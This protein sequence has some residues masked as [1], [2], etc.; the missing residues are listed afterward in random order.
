MTQMNSV[1][2]H[3]L[4]GIFLIT[5]A[6]FSTEAEAQRISE[7]TIGLRIGSH[8]GFGAEVS[9]QRALGTDNR[10]EFGLAW[11]DDDRYDAIRALGF[12]QWVFPIKGNFN[13]YTGPGASIGYIDFDDDFLHTE[14]SEVFAALTGTI[15]IEYYFDFPL[16]LSLDLRPEIGFGDYY[17]DFEINL[18]ISARYQF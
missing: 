4:L 15:G 17:D 11:E 13:W 9:Y 18:G 5:V 3:Y 1:L 6:L 16:L 2:K 14:D 7:N 10:L 12:Y 8:D